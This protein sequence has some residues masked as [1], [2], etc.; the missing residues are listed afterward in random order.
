MQK[1]LHQQLDEIL[2]EPSINDGVPK[3]ESLVKDPKLNSLRELIEEIQQ[4]DSE[5]GIPKPIASQICAMFEPQLIRMLE[6]IS[7]YQKYLECLL[8][9]FEAFNE[10][11]REKF[12]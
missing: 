2:N 12:I 3:L 10:V 4:W 7:Y 8:P 6:N 5:T 1:W 11:I 9:K